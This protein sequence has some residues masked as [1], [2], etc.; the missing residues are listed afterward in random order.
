M[1]IIKSIQKNAKPIAK[2]SVNWANQNHYTVDG[3]FYADLVGEIVYFVHSYRD[4]PRS[5]EKTIKGSKPVKSSDVIHGLY[6][7]GTP[8]LEVCDVYVPITD[9]WWSK[10]LYARYLRM[11][12]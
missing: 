6:E 11:L 7:D 10:D 4:T 1:S 8:C 5:P 9:C 3:V 2:I 12:S